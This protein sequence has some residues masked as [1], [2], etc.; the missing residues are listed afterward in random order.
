MGRHIY[1]DVIGSAGDRDEMWVHKFWVGVQPSEVG[2][3]LDAYEP[4][5]LLATLEVGQET[6]IRDKVAEL[7][8][9]FAD[10]YGVGYGPYMKTD[11]MNTCPDL[12]TDEGKTVQAKQKLA[13]RINLGEH[14]LATIGN[15]KKVGLDSQE[16]T[17][18]C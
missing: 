6:A 4:D 9:E 15:M 17:I 14:L 18:E 8:V 13:A 7:E 11:E 12:T 3:Y 10:K 1:A 2:D 5:W 16:L